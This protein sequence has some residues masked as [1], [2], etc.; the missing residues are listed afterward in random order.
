[1]VRQLFWKEFR[2]IR[3]YLILSNLLAFLLLA[4]LSM[5]RR[6]PAMVALN[7]SLLPLLLP[8]V[9]A[10]VHAVSSWRREW[11]EHHDLLLLSLPVRG[12]VLVAAKLT[13]ALLETASLCTTIVLCLLLMGRTEQIQPVLDFLGTGLLLYWSLLLILLPWL[14]GT[15]FLHILGQ[16]AALVSRITPV[17]A[18]LAAVVTFLVGLWLLIRGGGTLGLLLGWMPALPVYVVAL[19]NGVGF[20][21]RLHLQMAPLYGALVVVAGLFW[22]SVWLVEREIEA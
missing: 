1:M 17:F 22:V 20:S 13:M 19:E 4:Y 11:T 2:E 3:T 14:L 15:L 5:D 7:L 16:V 12:W 18:S 9:R 21:A 6:V 8:L 10:P